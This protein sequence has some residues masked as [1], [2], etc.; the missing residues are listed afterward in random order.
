[1]ARCP[2]SDQALGLH[3]AISRRDLL[4]GRVVKSAAV[5]VE[6]ACPFALGSQSPQGFHAVCT[7]SSGEGDSQGSAGNTEGATPIPFAIYVWQGADE[8]SSKRAKSTTAPWSGEVRLVYPPACSSTDKQRKP[9][10]RGAL[11]DGPF[12]TIAFS[13]PELSRA[14]DHRNAFI[15]PHRALSQLPDG[16]LT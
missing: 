10:A 12:G 16:V 3:E 1:M 13:H 8:I 14:M 7:G 6:V 11:R 4:D 9:A 2:H 15:E 5:V